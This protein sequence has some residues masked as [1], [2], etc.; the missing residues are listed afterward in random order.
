[1]DS[2]Q[3]I[4]QFHLIRPLWLL[5]VF[6]LALA[7]WLYSR[8]EIR[9]R[10]WAS[11]IDKRL[12]PHLLQGVDS[13]KKR[14]PVI[15]MFILGLLII[16]ALAGPAFNKLPQPVFKTQSAL[17]IILDLS[18]S[19]DATDIKPSRLSRAHFKINDIIKMRKEGQTALI[20][21]A[22]DA[23]IVSPL[24]DDADTIASQVSALETYIMPS[25]GSRLDIALEKALQLFNNAGHSK[26]NILVITDSISSNDK[27]RLKELASKN[28]ITSILAVGTE[29]G[30]PIAD[31]EGGFVK[32]K[33]G[34]IVVPKLDVYNIK[35]AAFSAGG[36]FSLLTANDNDINHLLSAIDI[37]SNK[38]GE[39]Q[40]DATGEKF[41]TDIWHE[42]GPWLLLFVIP[43][44]AYVFRKGLIFLI[45]VFVLPL[46][47]PAQ[48]F[49]WTDLWKNSNQRGEIALQEGNTELAADLFNN[50]E[51]KS[52]AQYK[53]GNYQQSAELLSN[54]DTADANYNR[55][56][57][58]AKAGDL[59]GAIKAYT[60]ALEISP[61][62][63]DAKHNKQLLEKS[64]QEQKDKQ[65][66]NDKKS[67]DKNQQQDKS[68]SESKDSKSQISKE[69]SEKSSNSNTENQNQS[70]QSSDEE[71]NKESSTE[72]KQ[73]DNTDAKEEQ[74]QS[75]SKSESDQQK[76]EK[77]KSSQQLSRS[78]E[79]P[80]LEQQQTQQWLNKIPDDP[81]GLLRRKFK[82][83]YSREQNHNEENPW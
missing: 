7:I 16:F 81:G 77:N 21:Y 55:G 75:A 13:S 37:K 33:K 83:Q 9:S 59:S 64:Q 76:D 47:Q 10:S 20:A 51:W 25:Q 80:D 63:E 73:Q 58:L 5:A 28:Y 32:D 2:L 14:S 30:A 3:W 12:L 41:T 8:N 67:D 69:N 52:A 71:Q 19:M 6:P 23:Y 35:N 40:S 27:K 79:T 11:V 31:Q 82:Y 1:M 34:S 24:T 57:A 38:L 78:E 60:R 15:G 26:G 18:R 66:S 74:Q 4:Q 17:V 61:D 56:N 53:A 42:E 39:E 68:D 43:F 29:D 70:Q 62:H 36:K 49:G 72:N 45:L 50:P 48:A 22:A 65:Q 46:P 44:A 54:I